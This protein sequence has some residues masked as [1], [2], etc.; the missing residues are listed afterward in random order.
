MK[1]RP[2]SKIAVCYDGGHDCGPFVGHRVLTVKRLRGNFAITTDDRN[3]RSW[4]L[5]K[6]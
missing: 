2:G 4:I 1:T 5:L 3:V 6:R